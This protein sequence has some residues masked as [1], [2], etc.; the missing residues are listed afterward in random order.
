MKTCRVLLA[1]LFG[2][3]ASSAFAA[4][5]SE[6]QQAAIHDEVLSRAK[7]FVA[8]IE[9]ADF[10]AAW[11]Y[12]AEVPEFQWADA[13]GRA[14][15][16]ADTRKSWQ[17]SMGQ[18]RSMKYPVLQESVLVLAPDA[19]VYVANCTGELTLK[20]GTLL[21][22]G[23]FTF[24]SLWKHVGG[25]WKIV[26]CHESSLP[27]E[28]VKA[29]VAPANAPAGTT[30]AVLRMLDEYFA[31]VNARDPAKFLGFFVG[32]ED[33]TVFEDNDLRLSRK[34]FVAFVDG[35]FKDVSQIQA[36]WERRTVNEL[37][38]NV[39]I[40]TGTF[41]VDAK[42]TKG[43]PMAFRN[44][45]TY[46][47]VKQG[48]RWLMK[49]VHESS[50]PKE[51]APTATAPSQAALEAAIR[52]ADAAWEKAV[53]AK[54]IDQTLAFYDAEAVTAGPAMF[55]ARGLPAFRENWLKLF[56]RP[57]FALTWKSDKVAVSESATV[58]YS[59]G[60]WSM[61]GPS[62]N[63]PYLAVW[64][65]Q[66]DGQWKVLIDAAWRAV[67]MAAAGDKTA[68]VTANTEIVEP[69]KPPRR[70]VTGV[71]A[72]GKSVV[73]SDGPVPPEGASASKGGNGADLWL[74]DHVPADLA[75]SHDPIA[76]YKKR[77]W[78]PTGGVIARVATWPPGFAVQ[79]HQSATIDFV[80]I[81]S[82]SLELLLEEGSVTL[83][84]GD[85]VVQR[86]TKHGWRVV[87]DQP[88]TLAAVL[89]AATK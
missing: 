64:R 65:K 18:C 75:D 15:G 80:F 45:F 32:T 23:N 19:A 9:R 83:G 60:T 33:L 54:S 13:D 76:G 84:P 46:V 73:V 24:S 34:D 44:A 53:E 48:E 86:G 14:Y 61:S 81:I 27:A 20:D 31:A 87:G 55:P 89:L 50:L 11:S 40:V 67:P 41:K 49:H 59:T 7:G 3:A 21:T 38:P 78:P 4:P 26:F 47:L 6:K 1:A 16:F 58:A 10:N 77:Q 52:E 39:A 85:S 25:A 82:G 70:V 69:P 68:Q 43:A 29:A 56:A 62:E 2:L 51:S 74:L 28:T 36:T 72:A 71:N 37:A 88:C 12:I 22:R 17:E 57:D 30:A 5:L 35:F 66:A 79:K 8:A 42:D 63:G